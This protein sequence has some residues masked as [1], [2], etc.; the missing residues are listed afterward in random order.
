MVQMS[1]YNFFYYLCRSLVYKFLFIVE[2]GY[3]ELPKALLVKK[4][5][6]EIDD[7]KDHKSRRIW[8]DGLFETDQFESRV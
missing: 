7:K 5:E 4:V 3:Y 2:E 6:V 1:I 8:Q